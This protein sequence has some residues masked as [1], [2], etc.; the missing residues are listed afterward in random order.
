MKIKN[1]NWIQRLSTRVCASHTQN[2]RFKRNPNRTH[3][4]SL[5]RAAGKKKT[6]LCL[7]NFFLKF[8]TIESSL[9]LACFLIFY[10]VSWPLHSHVLL[11]N[12]IE[13]K[14]SQLHD[15]SYLSP[16]ELWFFC[17]SFYLIKISSVWSTHS[18]IG[19][20]CSHANY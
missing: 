14:W 17:T 16:K 10:F 20:C 2:S 13:T 7:L 11:Q 6:W 4:L 15:A 5:I 18:H 3:T 12:L 9:L 1:F 8:K 19:F